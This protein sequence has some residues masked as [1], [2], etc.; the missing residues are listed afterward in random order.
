MIPEGASAAPRTAAVLPVKRFDSAKQRLADALTPGSRR[1]LT[2]AMVSDVLRA[3]RHASS[4]DE[5]TVVTAEPA[6]QALA[7][8]EGARV[9]DEPDEAGQS[10]AAALGIA[11]LDE[12]VERVLLVPGDCP[13]LDPAELDA[14]LD[15]PAVAGG[16]VVVVP[17]RHGTGT[18]A[19]LLAP[20][21]AIHPAF[22]P[23]SRERHERLAAQAG[24]AWEVRE[25]GSL[26]LD[27]DTGEDLD[28]LRAA[29]A[30]GRGLA[31]HTRGVL[32]RLGR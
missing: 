30:A 12:A 4:V 22:G 20:P 32:G 29:L 26:L 9:V 2:E 31:G 3:L 6:V 21:T 25:P 17:D 1:A 18:N 10:A 23:G 14:L 7:Q 11:A 19:L 8:G 5:V 13:G 24:V 27:V 15:R 28:A 16:E